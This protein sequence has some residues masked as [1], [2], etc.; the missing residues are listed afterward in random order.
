MLCR[1]VMRFVMF[2]VVSSDVVACGEIGV[3][4]GVEE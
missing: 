4:P 1:D 2:R 3:Q